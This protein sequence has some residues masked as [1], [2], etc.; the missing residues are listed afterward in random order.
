MQSLK[1]SPVELRAAANVELALRRS[2]HDYDF[3]VYEVFAASFNREDDD[4]QLVNEF[5]GGD[6]IDEVVKWQHSNSYTIDLSAR[7]HFKSTRLYARVM[8]SLIKHRY[9]GAEGWYLSYNDDMSSYHLKK[10]KDLVARNPYL[11]QFTDLKPKAESVLKYSFE[12]SPAIEWTPAGLLRFKRGI[13]ANYIFVDDPLK[14]PENKLEPTI[15]RKINDAF[16]TQLLPMVKK[17]GEC[18]VVGT[19]QT[20]EDFFFDNRL[21]EKFTVWI[22]P[23]I[24]STATRQALWPEWMD[25]DELEH[26]RRMAPR[27]FPQEYLCEPVYAADSYI[28]RDQAEAALNPNLPNLP[29]RE[30]RQLNNEWVEAG[31]DI[32]KKRHPSHFAVFKRKRIGDTVRSEQIH[33]KWMDGWDYRRQLEYLK[34]ADEFF[35]LSKLR[36]DNTRG[37]FESFAEGGD[38]PDH[39]E[40]IVLTHR[41]EHALAAQGSGQFERGEVQLVDDERQLSQLLAVN[42]DLKAVAGPQG[43]GDSFWSIMLALKIDEDDQPNIRFL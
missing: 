12:G 18:R 31:L 37:E 33:S 9:T 6:Y 38:L 17:Y 19:P 8:W 7:D 28:P 23:A 26:R 13:H 43:H 3:F 1:L 20:N 36:Y 15:I 40:P 10:I 27:T 29:L 24:V 41:T 22:A 39:W 16:I 25:F 4:G 14:D 42:S 2:E 21:R 11:R 32:G 30:H 35:N 34:L 5:V